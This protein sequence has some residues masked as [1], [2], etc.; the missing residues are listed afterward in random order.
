M[1]RRQLFELHDLPWCPRLFREAITDMLHSATMKFGFYGPAVPL[2]KRALEEL[3]RHEMVDLCSGASGPVLLIYDK[4]AEGLDYEVKITLTDLYPNIPAFRKAALATGGVISFIEQPVDA[5]AVPDHLRGF[6]TLFSSFHHFDPDSAKRI[7][8][9]AVEK[10][11]GIGVFEI[12]GR[13]FPS[14]LLMLG[15]PFAVLVAM[16]FQKPLSWKRL[17]WT[18]I[19]PAIP[20]IAAWDGI[21]SNLRA[22]SPGELRELVSGIPADGY[23][24]EVGQVRGR[25]FNRITYL[26]GHPEEP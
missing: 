20:L 11:E 21:A 5:T 13:D 4:L 19:V 12:N 17:F 1:A 16:P 15:L 14:T 2:L 23:T 9:D 6:R 26:L 10:R 18:Y 25:W 24:W 3:D 22:Y 7:L 8:R